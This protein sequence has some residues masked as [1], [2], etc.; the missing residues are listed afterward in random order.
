MSLVI[1][2]IRNDKIYYIILDPGYRI[3]SP[4]CFYKSSNTTNIKIDNDYLTIQK[5]DDTLYPYS[6][7]MQGYNRYSLN[8]TSCFCEEYFNCDYETLNPEEILFPL[9]FEVLNGYR[10][11]NYNEDKTKC[12]VLKVMILDHYLQCSDSN[13]NIYLTFAE[14]QAIPKD[15]L[16]PILKPFCDKLN[17]NILEF[18]DI[19]YFILENN[20]QFVDEIINKKVLKEFQDKN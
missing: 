19:L 16:C 12:A 18:I 1:P 10:M 8:E 14:L 2:T 20:N 6:M 4:I 3:P 15:K 17:Q 13:K 11:I 5:N 9:S 7:K